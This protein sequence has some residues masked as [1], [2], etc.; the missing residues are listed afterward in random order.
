MYFC[1]SE[2]L[3]WSLAGKFGSSKFKVFNIIII[4]GDNSTASG[5]CLSKQEISS[6]LALFYTHYLYLDN[7]VN[8]IESNKPIKPLLKG[9]MMQIST[10]GSRYDNYYF[11]LIHFESDDGWIIKD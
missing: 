10:E 6:D 8:G 4:F 5:T 3:D 1:P 9:D 7:Y 11:K 2:D